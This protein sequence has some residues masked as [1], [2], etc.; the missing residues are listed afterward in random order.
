[1]FSFNACG[2]VTID[3]VPES[4]GSVT[5]QRRIIYYPEG[6]GSEAASIATD[7][8][9]SFCAKVSPGKYVFKVFAVEVCF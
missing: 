5:S 7:G 4:L 3:R 8:A 9:G 1:M 6:K 2:K